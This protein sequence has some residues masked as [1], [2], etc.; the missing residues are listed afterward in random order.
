MT[1][2]LKA[3]ISA[4]LATVLLGA[5]S[6]AGGGHES[7]SR[8]LEFIQARGAS[9]GLLFTLPPGFTADAS[10]AS[11]PGTPPDAR[12]YRLK[13][14]DVP[15]RDVFL[16]VWRMPAESPPQS[17]VIAAAMGLQQMICPTSFDVRLLGPL[18]RALRGGAR[19]PLIPPAESFTGIFGC[20][21]TPAGVSETTLMV[22]IRGRSSTYVLTW[23][24][25]GESQPGRAI[26]IDEAAWLKRLRQITPFRLCAT[27]PGGTGPSPACALEAAMP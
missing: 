15:F 11:A 17:V 21:Q 20:G 23:V 3:S 19:S 18:E 9:E 14:A 10:P 27:A 24:Q 25:R 7:R 4:M 22:S 1:D 2:R 8:Q 26:A 6:T 12:V 5:C 16:V 13:E